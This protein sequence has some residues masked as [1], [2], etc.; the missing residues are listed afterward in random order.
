MV[1]MKRSPGDL[2]NG[3]AKKT[4]VIVAGEDAIEK[5]QNAILESPKNYNSIVTLIGH[6]D[7]KDGRIWHKSSASLLKIFGKLS[8]S[9]ALRKQG[10]DAADA[11]AD[12]LKERYLEFKNSL[13]RQLETTNNPTTA[14]SAFSILMKLLSIES[15]YQAPS[16]DPYYPKLLYSSIIRTVMVT[17]PVQTTHV[18]GEYLVKEYI[19]K[20]DDLLYYFYVELAV[21]LTEIQTHDIVPLKQVSG[22]VGSVLESITRF[23]SNDDE[24]SS[25]YLAKPKQSKTA[26]KHGSPLKES[27]YK[28]AFQKT[29]MAALQL[30]QSV[31]QYKSTL[32]IL[33]QRIIPNMHKPQMLMDFLTDCY[34]SGGSVSLLALNG[35]FALMQKYNLDYPNFYTKL[36]A[37]FDGSIMH[38]KYRSR[39]FRLV[40]LFLSSSHLPAAVTAS[41]IKK[42]ARLALFAPPAAVVATVPFIYNQLKRHPTCMKMIH[43]PDGKAGQDP[44][45]EH[46]ED[47]LLTNAIDSSLWEIDTLQSH[48]H[49]NVSTLA[50]IMSQ[51]F[52]K[53]QYL[54]EDFLDHSY[55]SLMQAE[56]TRRIRSAL[57]A[58]EFETY[59]HVF[60][61]HEDAGSV[62]MSGWTLK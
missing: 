60:A 39:F 61:G 49:P 20:Y 35:L 25:F 58:L 17:S 50:K 56:Q 12:W 31:E 15:K 42:M 2:L 34:N 45:D 5:L 7:S 21:I 14:V 16:S 37:L 38:A 30:P 40:D 62:Y 22:R 11:I 53:P 32:K 54:L 3:S 28:V 24:I 48:Y 4:K 9:G 51:P 10:T 57:P 29:W 8:K 33:H 18:T 26:L 27:S 41:F 55:G 44:F 59:D 47:P 6:L 52:R 36:Y 19:H 1:M 23:P 46:E 13:L 43:N